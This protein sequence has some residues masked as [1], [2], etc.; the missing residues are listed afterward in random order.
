MKRD[1][2][3]WRQAV[4]T[5]GR[6]RPVPDRRCKCSSTF[7]SRKCR[8]RDRQRRQRI[9]RLQRQAAAR[10]RLPPKPARL[11]SRSRPA[12]TPDPRAGRAPLQYRELGPDA[13]GRPRWPPCRLGGIS[14]TS[15]SLARQ[16]PTP[17]AARPT[18]DR[19][20]EAAR[21]K[22]QQRRTDE[23][24]TTSTPRARATRGSTGRPGQRRFGWSASCTRRA[25]TFSCSGDVVSSRSAAADSPPAGRGP[26]AG[27]CRIRCS[28][29][30]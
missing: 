23:A 17:G 19:S 20:A 7:A 21:R 16:A 30:P 13:A 10:R 14:R 28:A 11:P 2:S 27:S 6:I 5:P 15:L 24:V 9:L 8:S 3:S 4:N 26:G 22:V 29:R 1:S 18:A 25:A 12:G